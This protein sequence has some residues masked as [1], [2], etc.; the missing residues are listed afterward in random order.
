MPETVPLLKLAVA[1][2][3]AEV[4]GGETLTPGGEV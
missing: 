2:A 1:L 4:E 3:V